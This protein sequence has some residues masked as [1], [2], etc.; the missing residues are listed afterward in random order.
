MLYISVSSKRE[1]FYIA[2]LLL[3]QEAKNISICRKLRKKKIANKKSRSFRLFE[4]KAKAEVLFMKM[5]LI[6][7]IVTAYP[8][9]MTL[10]K[11][12]F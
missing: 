11:T 5:W 7:V 9:G 2:I 8:P 1:H 4:L 12:L 6:A 3:I 10:E